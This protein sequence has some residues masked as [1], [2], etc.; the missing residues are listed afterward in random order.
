MLDAGTP[1]DALPAVAPDARRYRWLVPLPALAACAAIAAA[2]LRHTGSLAFPI[3]DGYIYSN[4][5]AEAAR[6]HL[7]TYNAG[8]LSG[9]ITS[10]GWYALSLLANLVLAPA[11]ALMGGLAPQ[12]LQADTRLAEEAGHSYLSAYIPG[13]LLLAVTALGLYRLLL[14]LVPGTGGS[15]SRRGFCAAA[16]AVGA[17][18]PGLA[19]GAMSGLEVPLS[20][21]AAV[22]AVTLLSEEAPR[23][24]LRWS[25]LA[26]ALLPLARPD[27]VVVG[28]ACLGWLA[29][30]AVLLSEGRA[31]AASM[32]VLYLGALAAGAA[33]MA[34]V[35]VVGWGKPL[36][37]SFF[38][39]VGG[40][41]FGARFF[42]ATAELVTA[43]SWLPFAGGALA[44][45]AGLWQAAYATRR[46]DEEESVRARWTALL[47]LVV[48]AAYVAA[49]MLTLPWFGQEDRY[50]LP[51][52]P[53]GFALISAALWRVAGRIVERARPAT[54]RAGVAIAVAATVLGVY[55]WATRLYVV[56]VRN[57]SDGHIAPALWL[58]ANSR[59]DAVI[60]AEPIG[61]VR[62]FSG[63]RTVDLVG[64]TTP[65]TLGTYR[66][67]PRAWPALRAAG[68]EY[69]LFYPAWF[70]AKRPPAFATEVRRFEIPDNRIA[71]DG[72]IA[73]YRLD[74][75][76]YNG[77]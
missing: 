61:A 38:A 43:G 42:S 75:A 12:L 65:A 29:L 11:K 16:G 74:W 68:A 54:A 48:L 46:R 34:A 21:A 72:V 36:P 53:F 27:L 55:L 40:L 7:F 35:Y 60:A 3:D 58:A 20:T 71:G 26:A 45:G 41:R 19:W 25:L 28:L 44:L 6:G 50:L 73:I 64:L 13:V 32:A 49:M 15:A 8:E 5:V 39:K 66:D 51:V 18:S 37:S 52:Q 76:R 4:Y 17:C 67:W 62:L 10:A 33:V 70:D 23:G 47:V 63:R 31:G 24:R 9:G 1:A 30:R 56:E 14:P 77:P 59:E 69:L 22:W 57:I 2:A